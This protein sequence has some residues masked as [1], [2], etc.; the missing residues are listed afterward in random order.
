MMA[1]AHNLITW[2]KVIKLDGTELKKA[3]IKTLVK[4]C[5]R[6]RG[7]VERTLEGIRVVIPPL[8]KLARLLIEAL[9]KPDYVQLSFLI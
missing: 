8:S 6:I 7:F 1:M 4:K 2:F 9:L 3:G 5:S